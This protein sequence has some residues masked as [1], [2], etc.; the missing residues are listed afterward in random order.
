MAHYNNEPFIG[1]V[2][3]VDFVGTAVRAGFSRDAVFEVML[4]SR[5]RSRA[6]EG[7]TVPVY[8]MVGARKPG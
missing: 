6:T 5:Y 3:D 2:Q 4:P 7:K 1:S 8:F